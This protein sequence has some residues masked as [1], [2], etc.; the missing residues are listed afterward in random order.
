MFIY[1]FV[2]SKVCSHKKTCVSSYSPISSQ[3]GIVVGVFTAIEETTSRCLHDRRLRTLQELSA[4]T[5]ITNVA[6]EAADAA[7]QVFSQNAFDIP[8]ACLYLLNSDSQQMTLCNVIG[9]PADE[10]SIP[11]S[12]NVGVDEQGKSHEHPT[13]ANYIASEVRYISLTMSCLTRELDV[14]PDMKIQL[15]LATIERPTKA[16]ILPLRSVINT[17]DND[18]HGG[19]TRGVLLLGLNPRK[20]LD[21][22]YR[23][24]LTLLASALTAAPW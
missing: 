19:G 7:M 10:P 13:V 23:T 6:A 12:V 1:S 22:A 5:A 11:R 14:P 24:F 2:F 3:D 21:V 20:K 4:R 18:T 8:F 17:V 15:P 16:I 9:T